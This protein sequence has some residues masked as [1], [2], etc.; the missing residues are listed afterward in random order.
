MDLPL[1]TY[2]I[3]QSAFPEAKYT[4]LT[5]TNGFVLQQTELNTDFKQ[6]IKHDL[7]RFWTGKQKIQYWINL[8]QP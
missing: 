8:S 2:F 1:Y 3:V 5:R 6:I 7:F 4:E